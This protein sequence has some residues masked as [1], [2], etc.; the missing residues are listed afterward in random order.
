LKPVDSLSY[1]LSGAQNG[2]WM[3]EKLSAN[4]AQL[5]IGEYVEI[6]GQIDPVLFYK[7]LRQVVGESETLHLRFWEEDDGPR[8][9]VGSIP[10]WTPIFVDLSE[11]AHPV[12]AAETWM[13]RDMA[14][15]RHP[16][17]D[18]LFRH[19]LFRLRPDHYIWYQSY[20]HLVMDGY[21]ML[22]F[23]R[24]L[25]H[26]Y[27][28]LAAGRAPDPSPFEDLPSL[29]AQ[30]ADYAGSDTYKQ[31]R[32][33]WLQRLA[34]RAEPVSLAS[35]ISAEGLARPASIGLRRTNSIPTALFEQFCATASGIGATWPQMIIAAM[36]I[37]V[38][39]MVGGQEVALGIPVTARLGDFARATPAMMANVLPMQLS[40]RPEA[41]VSELVHQVAGELR[42][43]LG[44]QRYRGEELTRELHRLKNYSGVFGPSVNIKPF[45]YEF[46]FDGHAI[47]AHDL[48]VGPVGDL[49]VSIYG[50]TGPG[51]VRIDFDANSAWY[52]DDDLV[53][54]HCRLVRVLTAMAMNP[55]RRIGTIELLE[56]EERQQILTA[57]NDTAHPG[58]AATLPALFE[59]QV[60]RTPEATALIF[61]NESLS[62]AELNS[63]A[64]QLA[65]HLIG[66]GIGPED[67]VA[68]CLPRSIEML[69]GLLAILKAG[70]AYVPLD[71]DY[72]QA[73][74]TFMLE[75][76]APRAI[77]TTSA[78]TEI[79]QPVVPALRVD[80]ALTRATVSNASE[81][82]PTD[83]DR[84]TPLASQNPAY[85]I[86]TSG[87][88]GTPKGV[89]VSHANLT[90]LLMSMA[91]AL[92]IG[93][94][95]TLLATTTINFDIAGLELYLPL[96]QGGRL[97][98][99]PQAAVQDPGVLTQLLAKSNASYLQATPSGWQGLL[100]H[101][102]SF[103][104][105]L[106]ILVGG[107]ALSAGQAA[108]MRKLTDKEIVNLYGPTETTIWSVISSLD[109]SAEGTPPI[110][111]PIW[112]TRVYVLDSGLCPVP[113]GVAGELY[114]AGA[115]LAHGYL[116][117]PGLTAE[118][119]VACPFGP[120][121]ERMYRTGD[122]AK[123]R[124][125]GAL[126]F[127]GRADHQV[128]VRGFRIEPGEIEAALTRLPGVAQAAVVAREDSPGEKRL[129]GYVIGD[130]TAIDPAA[131]RRALGETLPDYM[132]PAAV[133]VLEA[134]PLTPNGKL[135]RRALPAP[136]FTPVSTRAAR[137]PQEEILCSLFAEVLGLARVGID[138]DFFDLGGHSLLATRLVSRIRA[139]LNIELPIR[140]LFE[141]P[142]VAA[143]ARQL[144]GAAAAR[145]ALCLQMRPAT[146]PLSFAQ[147]RLWFLY[148]LEGPSPTYNMA[149]TLRLDGMVDTAALEAAL[150][151]LVARHE[152]LRTI[153]PETEAGLCQ[154]VLKVEDSR[155][156]I[157]LKVTTVDADELTAALRH[158]AAYGFALDREIPIRTTLFR[159]E[160]ADWGQADHVLLLL[161]HHIASDG[162]SQAPLLRDLG[163]AYAARLEGRAPGWAPLPV[164]Y[165]DYTLWQ[166]EL[167]GEEE[168]GKSLIARQSAYWRQALAGLPELITL[169]TDRPRPAISSY[170]GDR[171]SFSIDEVLHQRLQA[172]AR[173]AG[174]S[175]FMVL[176]AG[177]AVLLG[178]LGAGDDIAVGTPIAGRMDE[179]LDGLNGFFVNTLVLR[180]D[181]SGNPTV[182]ELIARVRETSLGAYAHQDLPFERLV[183]IL[184][185]TRTP[186][187]QPLF[188]VT[189]VL[190]NNQAPILSLPG[191]TLRPEPIATTTAKFDLTVDLTET[192]E[193][194]SGVIEYATD[195]Y[196]NAGIETLAQRLVRVLAAMDPNRR[197]DTIAL[198]E[199]KEQQQILTGWNNTTHPVPTATLPALFEA[200]VARTPEAT[201]LVFE[202]SSLSYAELNSRANRLAH[203]LIG[204]GIGPEDRV[205]LC[206]PRSIE[207]VV[208]LLAILKAGAAY[209][210]LDPNY[211]QSRLAFMLEDAAPK[212][213]I[214][215]SAI[216]E[217]LQ[218]KF[219]AVL[220][221][222]AESQARINT[223]P[224]SNPANA[225]RTAPL[226]HGHPA[227]V[228]YTSGSTGTPKGVVVSTAGAQ[229]LYTWYGKKYRFSPETHAVV[230]SSF[231]F[232]LTQKNIFAALFNGARLCLAS[233]AMDN[234]DDVARYLSDVRFILNCAPSQFHAL[235]NDLERPETIIRD[236]M[237]ILGGEKLSPEL[238]E[239]FFAKRPSVH[240]INSY[241]PTE[242]TDVCVDGLVKG[243]DQAAIDTIGRPIWNTRVYVLDRGL[244]PVPVGV[245]GELYIAGA[246]LA[247]GYL[248]RPGL[249]AERFV[250]CPF[251]PAGERMYRTGDLA[252]WRP[253][254]MLDCLGRADHQ[255]KIRGF[256][257]EPGEIEA[258][259]TRLPGV[260]QAAVVAREDRP[261][262][263]RLVG[264]V[265]PDNDERSRDTAVEAIRVADWQELYE[266]IYDSSEAAGFGE[267]FTGWLSSIDRQP[268][269]LDQMRQW[270]A[271][272]VTRIQELAPRRVL[273]IGVGSG[274]LLSQLAPGCEAY[275]AT[276]FS[277]K[278]IEKLQHQ[279]RTQ[280]AW[281]ERGTLRAQPAHITEGL[282]SGFFDTVVLNSVV[283]YFPTAAYLLDV[284]EQV[285]GLLAPGGA[286]FIGDVRNLHLLRS[287]ASATELHKSDRQIDAA[288][289][290]G[291]IDRAVAAEKELLLAPEF[292]AL[293]PQRLGAIAAVD[294]RVKSGGYVNELS[295][296]RYDVVLHKAPKKV[297]PLDN[298]PALQWGTDVAGLAAVQEY[299]S[300]ARPAALR[301][302]QVPNA[303]LVPE[304]AVMRALERGQDPASLRQAE[305]SDETAHLPGIEA[306]QEL[307]ASLG[308]QVAIT[309][310]DP[311]LS[312]DGLDVVFWTSD[313]TD[314]AVPGHLF[315]PHGR[316]LDLASYANS[317]AR[318]SPAALRRALGE[319]LPDYMVPAALVVLDTLPL[320]P[321]G[322][323]DR[324]ALPAP[325]FTP[326][327]AR[328]PRTR[329]EEILC[330]L[331]AEVLGL[332]RVGIDD[333]FFDLGGHSL[334]ATRLVSRIRASLN[335]ELPIRTLFEAPTVAALAGRLGGAAAARKALRPQARPATLPL[336]FAQQR[337]WFLY[338]LEGPSPTYN[339][340]FTLR[341]DGMV[342]IAALEAA[343]ADLVVRHESLRTIYP[344]TEAGP[345][346]QILDVDDSRARLDLRM[347]AIDATGLADA[348]RHE[349][350]YGFMLDREI[351]IRTV[352]FRLGQTDHALL[353]LIH[354]IA[355]D[356][357]SQAPLLR[358]LGEAYAA[359]RDRRAP[360]WAPLPV[361]Y[362]DYTLWQRELLGE[363]DD[364]HS[365]VA[366]QSAYWRQALAGL[367]ELIALPTDRPRPAV[368]SYR[369]DWMSF[370]IDAVLHQRLQ[371]IARD[372]GSSLFMVLQAG[373]AALLGKLGAGDDI[374]VGSPIAGR[375]DEALDG[376]NGF[377]VNT[378]VLRTD[379]SGNPTVRELVV[380]AREAS[381]G[382]YA[383]QDMPFER[384]VEILNPTRTQNYQ[385]LFQVTLALQN[386]QAPVLSLPG[387]VVRSQPTGTGT[388]KFD[389]TVDL[390]ETAEGLS[391][392]IEYAT[393]LY[394]RASI[395]TLAQRLKCVLAAMAM[396]PD[397]R[398]GT[399]ELLEAEERQRILTQWN[400]TAHP[401]PAATLP[402]LFE[403]QVARTPEATA[404][405]FEETSLSYRE[406][407]SRANRLAHYLIGQGIGPEDRVAL[408]LPRSVE[409]VV[410]LLG[411]VKAGAAY[412]PLDPD[413]PQSRLAFMLADAAPR[414]IITH[415]VLAEALQPT[416]PVL[417]LDHA[418]TRAAIDDASKANPTGADRTRPLTLQHPAY[419]IYTSGSTGTPKGV[420]IEHDSL[421]N[422]IIW[423]VSEFS[424]GASDV[425]LQR[426]SIAFD[427]SG[428]E[429]WTPLT[430]GA[431]LILLS[432]EAQ[433]DPDAILSDVVR[434]GVTIL[435]MVPSL[436]SVLADKFNHNWSVRHLFCG[437]EALDP[438]L[439]A[440][441][442]HL[443]REGMHNLYGPTEITID[444]TAWSCKP[445]A[446]E[447]TV[448]IGRPIW[449][450]RVYVLDG[451]LRPVPIGVAGELYIAGAGLARGYLNRPGLTAE[452][453]VACPFGAAGERMYRTSDLAKWRPDGVLDF[454]GRADHQVK[455]RGFR[456]EP[457]EI[458]AA[459]TRL[460]GVAQAAVVAR[461]DRPGEKRLVGYIVAGNNER[462]RDVAAESVHVADWQ[463]LYE[464]IYQS[465]ETT[466]FGE[467]FTGWLNSVDRQPIALAEMR[468]WRTATVER[469]RELAPRRVLEIGVGSGLL[470]SQLAPGCEAY[471]ATD[472]STKTIENLQRQ[473]RTQPA[474]AERV[475]LRAQPAHITEGLPA[476]FFDTVVLNSVVQYF[477]T[478]AYLLD[479]IRQVLDLLAPGG[480]IFIGDVRNLHLLRCFASVTELYKSDSQIDAAGLRRQI[481]RA[482][483]TEKELLLG[484]EF[485]AL[486]P[487]R[488]DAVAAVDLQIKSGDYV[489]ELS[490]YRYDV[491]L[492]K[493][494]RKVIPLYDAP[495]LQWGT[496]AADLA[497]VQDHLGR[498]HPTALRLSQVPNARLVSELEVMRALERSQDLASLRQAEPANETTH[499]PGIE[500]F[501]ALG[502]SLGYRVGVTWGDP[503][504]SLEGLDVVFWR[505]ESADDAIPDHLFRP[506]ERTLD[507]TSYAN[508]PA[509]LDPAMLR[510]ALGMMLPDYMVPAAVLVLDALPLTPNGKLDRRALP[511]PDFMPVSTRAPRTP[512][513]E[514]LC[515][516]FAEVLGLTQ[517]GVDDDFFDLGGHSLL[518]T[519]L[520]SRI[521]AS[522]NIELPIRTLFEAPTVNQLANAIPQT[523]STRPLLKPRRK[524]SR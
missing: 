197:I 22:L 66:E 502:V 62:Y 169:P 303:R 115:G 186:N 277:T 507:P 250:A 482:V 102:N 148:R 112:N 136:E 189:L 147:Q 286:V 174:A 451:G 245:A 23:A 176:Q 312:L 352:L 161:I 99:A 348:L 359:R 44:H 95:D 101:P 155:A 452:R 399:I 402:V 489:N 345:Y 471:W 461:E 449:N 218:A 465:P 51:G 64:N 221:D 21:G 177:L 289:L 413:Y 500:T 358:D 414:A 229:N 179:A 346:Q 458:E 365:L 81:I 388:A 209:V 306:F 371:E 191:L 143:L 111:R 268:I 37:Y 29:L 32:A 406:L 46:R 173:D 363:E 48:G 495:T 31:D 393:D 411:I 258:A 412:V 260:A 317:P 520:V 380:R 194:L 305:P 483:T 114:I 24:R 366:R 326:V 455:I 248:N 213:T 480:A 435:Q 158:E 338:R 138:D 447:T 113:V 419:V 330:S 320:T 332:T 373:M 1:P 76:A 35:A 271:A 350:A 38:H 334:L 369:G 85:V 463:E 276:D 243:F 246:G 167:L 57:W 49:S 227:Y 343:L 265:V 117:R 372:T 523:P 171:M 462:S 279:L 479:V 347:T 237:I 290:R 34:D 285:H 391:G 287:F 297:I 404:L 242:I 354:H 416:V 309:W 203:H 445:S 124:L 239:G 178:K 47:T 296:Y 183:E 80:D 337:L 236:G 475:T 394:D 223:A 61:G 96:L 175:L 403:A 13:Q 506:R 490:R 182:R 263:Q 9:I 319:T 364:T 278:T 460:P 476:N 216:A 249:T 231:S 485:F 168:D 125:D 385:P 503:A 97:A 211:P 417:R 103:Q 333:D 54:H 78:I 11:N 307:A 395:E 226:R 77:I 205:A 355:S 420:V 513:E 196:D 41:T 382:A 324:R 215:T 224:T 437:G 65:H 5:N 106:R 118:R 72:P 108:Q 389:L 146:L 139:N 199:A 423:Q 59:A 408:C 488:L 19:A 396:D 87:S 254:G 327:S 302:T 244:R 280:P 208:G 298:S 422:H 184:N 478:A 429:L 58:P 79:L 381:L 470:L 20:H 368:S 128:K 4:S 376:L 75:D 14:T 477:P 251:G 273:E 162:W 69:V 43:M 100:D 232:D 133:V 180:T 10:D 522:L 74:L 98:I 401:V 459:L 521:R 492:H 409:M 3:A 351:P 50:R 83:A 510:R 25:A 86:Y 379:L 233:S 238:L 206:L 190:Q 497:A 444:A 467:D 217:T 92:Q 311:A 84:S 15:A 436:L 377:F 491:V 126:D 137:T 82:A 323:L 264:Y 228:I 144:G 53:E 36:A 284:I 94:D 398:I 119:F 519:R 152:S 88:T 339:M 207:M 234:A 259:L 499:L 193:G 120:A 222:S 172:M 433:K 456:I 241:G 283:Q 288:S 40:V 441:F 266:T 504:L 293:L 418:S 109:P 225:D 202:D 63:R 150:R 42:Q 450:T 387:L 353:L 56:A 45:D 362:A 448:P 432:R 487:E 424:F 331:F 356:G 165:A 518:A 472:F 141:A 318:L 170:R 26:V 151:D 105:A 446:D 335:I 181:L 116:N 33:Y 397:Q 200:Q 340:T 329:Q 509:H 466:S 344:E 494:P 316:M 262:E 166:R 517:V 310:G 7:A 421:A 453:F 164:Q 145:Q 270:R 30:E 93:R 195:L 357:W 508:S 198:L 257:I 163:E 336:S 71:P 516:L 464:T 253:D 204:Q 121:G 392:I 39:K 67:R 70:A 68:L 427:A 342:D 18:L 321:S 370:A 349:A 282:P 405:V 313:G 281:A 89:V 514:I 12:A 201:A 308:Y 505:S 442:R 304:L 415:T 60:A 426:T 524:I 275:W 457:G 16:Q 473:L 154:Q 160:Q 434:H 322:K 360:D 314:A 341:L 135:D 252:K 134:L 2:M 299:L 267:D 110:G 438:E 6:H 292:F 214:T 122:L 291:L 28:A 300:R 269:A 192:T 159:Q 90:N 156:L 400:D 484:P 496:E 131:L 153:Y 240:L 481:D 384:L 375:M 261:G 383:H 511:A 315:Q 8:Q 390:T 501:Q 247:R 274:L 469:I 428:W 328:T 256:R 140:T 27:S 486:L 255:V 55:D 142:T 104:R 188:Q 301:L 439:P 374:A 185:P 272:T 512:Q 361:Q 454:L 440:R 235:V 407:N 212:A 367:P 73:R 130:G 443:V 127:L 410:G 187:Y 498:E 220:L 132:V 386:N 17:S 474:W 52:T 107:E 123:W 431:Q 230:V 493:A 91:S 378:L 468:Q 325:D 425:F 210:P 157:N 295:R 430:L 149:F 515:S 294:V 219:S 129:V